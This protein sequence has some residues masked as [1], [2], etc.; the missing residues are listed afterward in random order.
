MTYKHVKRL[1]AWLAIKEIKIKTALRY[2]Y[3]PIRPTK[4]KISVNTKDH[5]WL[6]LYETSRIGKSIETESILVVAMGWEEEWGVRN[7]C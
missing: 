7:N 6:H 3:T 2:R 1:S 5:I 4:I